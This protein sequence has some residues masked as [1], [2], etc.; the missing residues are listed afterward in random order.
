M[1][2]CFYHKPPFV[3][4]EAPDIFL[5]IIYSRYCAVEQATYLLPDL[6]ILPWSEVSAHRLTT[7]TTLRAH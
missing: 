4:G 7:G 5:I 2:P 3:V 6:W 1:S